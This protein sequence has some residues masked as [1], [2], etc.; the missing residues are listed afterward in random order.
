MIR[1]RF[2]HTFFGLSL[3]LGLVVTY[4]FAQNDKLDLQIIAP[5]D[6]TAYPFIKIEMSAH[7]GDGTPF[8]GLTEENVQ[9]WSVD[10]NGNEE[11]SLIV[12]KVEP[13]PQKNLNLM[14]VVDTS[15]RDDVDFKT[16]I[17]ATTNLFKQLHRND[18]IG[19]ITFDE[20]ISSS[21]PLTTNH[22]IIFNHL[23]TLTVNQN[24]RTDLEQALLQA[25]T[26]TKSLTIPT[27]IV[28]LTNFGNNPRATFTPQTL[29]TVKQ[30][31]MPLYI[32]GGFDDRVNDN[33]N[34]LN[35]LVAL[36]HGKTILWREA[37]DVDV[38]LQWLNVVLRQGYQITF[39]TKPG[40]IDKS[41]SFVLRAFHTTTT[42]EIIQ[43]ET[44]A[45]YQPPSKGIGLTVDIIGLPPNDTVIN[46]RLV[47]LEIDD[48]IPIKT[49]TYQYNNQT[50]SILEAP[51]EFILDPALFHNEIN[52]L[53]VTATNELGQIGQASRSFTVVEPN[54][55]AIIP[56]ISVPL[57]EPVYLQAITPTQSGEV[58]FKQ[59]NH[60]IG[61]TNANN[62]YAFIWTN[63]SDSY[64]T[65]PNIYT[66][67]AEYKDRSG[68]TKQNRIL[69]EFTIPQLGIFIPLGLCLPIILLSLLLLALWLGYKRCKNQKPKTKELEL[70]LKN[71]GNVETDYRLV[72][73]FD[74]E[75]INLKFKKVEEISS[76]V[77]QPQINQPTSIEQ[78]SSPE[79]SSSA[80]GAN[81]ST[82]EQ[83]STMPDM[84]SSADKAKQG[85]GCLNS[86]VEIPIAILELVGIFIPPA[87]NFASN[88]RTQQ[89]QMRYMASMPGLIKQ[90]VT[91]Q[92]DNIKSKMGQVQQQSGI[93]A[94]SV[95]SPQSSTASA[96][97]TQREPAAQ[98]NTQTTAPA[99]SSQSSGPVQATH[100][101]RTVTQVNQPVSYTVTEQRIIWVDSPFETAFVN[102]MD[103]LSIT[104]QLIPITKKKFTTDIMITSTPIKQPDSYMATVTKTITF[105]N[106]FSWCW[107]IWFFSCLLTIAV[108][109]TTIYLLY[110]YWAW[111]WVEIPYL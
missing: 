43:G 5:I 110:V 40:S 66:I 71:K 6:T 49:V 91:S 89:S 27:T 55:L 57:G 69:V 108:T 56:K 11:T 87:R 65:I 77:E 61:S 60:T 68:T 72:A 78:S 83:Q 42:G 107:L 82:D 34:S 95:N 98:D 18:Q 93:S 64:P 76:V 50:A 28:I 106:P 46:P 99:Q 35:E 70:L 97:D 81:Q 16:V 10:E 88:L 2:A 67:I 53:V 32:I 26:Q 94:P 100:S 44:T 54:N 59:G 84:A 1:I 4:G 38:A 52:R 58:I 62:N 17:T 33:R 25:I 30:A 14:L 47:T 23:K 36:T 103:F 51:Y 37:E 12:D 75:N 102:P 39:H 73:Q 74:Q 85:M 24:K 15:M 8:I 7:Y 104:L 48:D 3:L 80:G 9:V 31:N 29:N 96:Q 20:T 19:L 63:Q 101:N 86:L 22:Q 90:Q 105:D 111:V 21:I 45:T 13:L 92:T 41:E 109:F 79:I